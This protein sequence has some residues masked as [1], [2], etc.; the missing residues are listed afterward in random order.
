M[1]VT[2]PSIPQTGQKAK[3]CRCTESIIRSVTRKSNSYVY[4]LVRPPVINSVHLMLLTL[5]NGQILLAHVQKYCGLQGWPQAIPL[6]LI[7]SHILPVHV[8][9]HELVGMCK[10]FSVAYKYR[11]NIPRSYTWQRYLVVLQNGSS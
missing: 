4:T 1:H 5:K 11:A 3:Q 8:T 2:I 10:Q 7:S 6:V 9:D